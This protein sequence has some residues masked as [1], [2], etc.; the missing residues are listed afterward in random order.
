MIETHASEYDDLT[1]TEN[2]CAALRLLNED[3]RWTQRELA[4]TFQASTSTIHRH[5][6]GDC[7]HAEDA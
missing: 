4:M 3:D 7:L 2:E 6:H 5:I 1:I